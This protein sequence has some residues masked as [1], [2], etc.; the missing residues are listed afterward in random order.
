MNPGMEWQKNTFSRQTLRGIV[1]GRAACPLIFI[2]LLL[3]HSFGLTTL[4]L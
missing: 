1:C 4:L 3:W 2:I